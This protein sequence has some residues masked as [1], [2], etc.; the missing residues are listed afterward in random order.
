VS[1]AFD[2]HALVVVLEAVVQQLVV[3]SCRD[4]AQPAE[5]ARAWQRWLE[6]QAKPFTAGA[7]DPKHSDEIRLRAMGIAGAFGSFSGELAA[8]LGL[9]E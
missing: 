7:F 2:D 5:A 9:P 3:M 8:A 6:A 4:S 1:D